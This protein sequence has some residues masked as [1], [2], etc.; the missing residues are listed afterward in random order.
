MNMR[1]TFLIL[2]IILY[3]IYV[4]CL[5]VNYGSCSTIERGYI[6]IL[7]MTFFLS[8]LLFNC[9]KKDKK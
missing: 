8:V 9:F 7:S 2:S 4:G 3:V 1:K 6:D 5:L